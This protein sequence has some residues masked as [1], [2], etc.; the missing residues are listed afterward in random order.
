VEH[1]A[2]KTNASERVEK[3]FIGDLFLMY[4]EGNIYP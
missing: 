1:A 2:R 3:F 4:D